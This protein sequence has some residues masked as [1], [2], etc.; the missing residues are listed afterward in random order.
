METIVT[1]L[2]IK[3][4][5]TSIDN[6]DSSDDQWK[7]NVRTYHHM[8]DRLMKTAVFHKRYYG[9]I[10]VILNIMRNIGMIYL[11]LDV[12]IYDNTYIHINIKDK[13]LFLHTLEIR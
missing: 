8:E 10:K 12:S 6:D 4:W 2:D 9:V 7:A 1:H 5:D 11:R 3:N 13:L